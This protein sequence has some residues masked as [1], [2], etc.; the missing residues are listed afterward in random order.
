MIIG[1]PGKTNRYDISDEIIQYRD[2]INTSRE[3]MR[4]TRL[5]VMTKMMLEDEK[6]YIQ[7]ADKQAT[8]ANYMK[9]AIGMNQCIKRL[10]IIDK[11]TE[12]E[13]EFVE[14]CNKNGNE[15]SAK[16]LKQMKRLLKEIEPLKFQTYM[17]YEEIG[18]AHV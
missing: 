3:K 13:R 8:S 5:D 2:I 15:A 6:I 14:W 11:K 9:N 7:Y 16:A 10:S 12:Q 1:F 4:K 18:R 17:L